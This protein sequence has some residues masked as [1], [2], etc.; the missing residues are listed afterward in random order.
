MGLTKAQKIVFIMIMLLLLLFIWALFPL[1][2]KWV[3]IG[4]GSDKTN[5]S[6]FGTFGDIYGSLNTL[7][8][9]ATLIIVMYS[10]YLQRQANNDAAEAAITQLEQTKRI[11]NL[12]IMKANDALLLQEKSTKDTNFANNF[13]NLLNYKEQRY[14]SLKA[15]MDGKNV[16]ADLI[17]FKIGRNF[18]ETLHENIRLMDEPNFNLNQIISPVESYVDTFSIDCLD[19]VKAYLS[20][21]IGII[22]L[23][24]NSHLTFKEKEPYFLLLSDSMRFHEQITLFG[25]GVA[26]TRLNIA[27]Q[28]SHIFGNFYNKNT[29]KYAQ[30]YYNKSCFW[31]EDFVLKLQK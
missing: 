30:K 8:T 22:E 17:F 14:N 21:Y 26:N 3:M 6:D 12:E 28:N 16:D 15:I 10:A 11:S 4:I 27:L 9:S 23:I 31:S 25:F 5:L 13:F 7:F 1:F 20:L 24:K 2:F 19:K 29:L 18:E